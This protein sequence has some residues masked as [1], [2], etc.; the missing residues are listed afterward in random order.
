VYDRNDLIELAGTR[1]A[2]RV[3]LMEQGASYKP[4][5]DALC[6]S[7]CTAQRSGVIGS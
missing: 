6:W 7:S 2:A 1:Q 4:A 3:Y 5:A